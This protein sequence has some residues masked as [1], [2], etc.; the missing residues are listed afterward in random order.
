MDVRVGTRRGL[1]LE[2]SHGK[3]RIQL[4]MSM[5]RYRGFVN[6]SIALPESCLS[7]FE[8]PNR[9][10]WQHPHTLKMEDTVIERL[11]QVMK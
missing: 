6:L 2:M 11:Y 9:L 7:D 10:H 1:S 5:G 4:G 8:G 3:D